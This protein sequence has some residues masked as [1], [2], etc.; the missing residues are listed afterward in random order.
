[1]L[2]D[3]L[4]K[5]THNLTR[6][7][8][9]KVLYALIQSECSRVPERIEFVPYN[10]LKPILNEHYTL[11]FIRSL[12]AEQYT[13]RDITSVLSHL[14]Q[15]SYVAGLNSVAS[16]QLQP[17]VIQNVDAE[18]RYIYNYETFEIVE[19]LPNFVKLNDFKFISEPV[20]F[21]EKPCIVDVES[22]SDSYLEEMEKL[23]SYDKCDQYLAFHIMLRENS[24]DGSAPATLSEEAS[25]SAAATT[26]LAGRFSSPDSLAST[27]QARLTELNKTSRS[28][29][30][31]AYWTG[32]YYYGINQGAGYYVFDQK[33]T[34]ASSSS[35]R[36]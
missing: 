12:K 3:V 14:Y 5:I 17:H 7:D 26:G 1:M 20:E 34:L 21:I 24:D 22:L 10:Q 33:N 13:P 16:V 8:F 4:Q 15:Y 19:R 18:G 36:K 25:T 32:Y 27:R 2:V 9:A 35:T 28:I 23:Y 6:A 30:S 31:K 29:F 11:A